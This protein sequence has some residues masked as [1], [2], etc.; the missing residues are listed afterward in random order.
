MFAR[1]LTKSSTVLLANSRAPSETRGQNWIKRQFRGETKPSKHQIS[2]PSRSDVPPWSETKRS[3]QVFR[4]HWYFWKW[5]EMKTHAAPLWR[6]LYKWKCRCSK[7]S[8]LNDVFKLV[9]SVLSMF[10]L[11]TS[12]FV[13]SAVAFAPGGRQGARAAVRM[14][15]TAT[16]LATDTVLATMARDARGLAIDSISAVCVLAVFLCLLV[17]ATIFEFFFDWYGNSS[18]E[19]WVNKMGSRRIEW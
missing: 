15:S 13:A 9:C 17:C 12:L 16:A 18:T 1:I 2:P 6:A 19:F 4:C 5:L 10:K 8:R 7:R 11:L 3:R 14:Q